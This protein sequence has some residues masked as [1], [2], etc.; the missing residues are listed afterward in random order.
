MEFRST[1]NLLVGGLLVGIFSGEEYVPAVEYYY[2]GYNG[3]SKDIYI[4]RST[5][6]IYIDYYTYYPLSIGTG[7]SV[8]ASCF[9]IIYNTNYIAY[10]SGTLT[11]YV[12]SVD[13][14]QLSTSASYLSHNYPTQAIS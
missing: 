9:H 10:L 8:M 7:R 12:S 2:Y 6:Y 5:Y 1:F 14:D 11:Y 4:G 3:S 13:S